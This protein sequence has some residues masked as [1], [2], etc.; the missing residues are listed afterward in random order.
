MNQIEESIFSIQ[1]GLLNRAQ[2]LLEDRISQLEVFERSK[3]FTSN[4]ASEKAACVGVF[5]IRS[6]KFFRDTLSYLISES[7]RTEPK[8]HFFMLPN[9]RALTNVHANFLHLLESGNEDKQALICIAYQLLTMKDLQNDVEYAKVLDMNKNFLATQSVVFPASPA[10]FSYKW[11]QKQKL[12]LGRMDQLLESDVVKKYSSN[13]VA[14]FM[15]KEQYRI[16]STLS[17]FLHGNPYYYDDNPHNERFWI[18]AFSISIT[19]FLIEIIDTYFLNKIN[20][21]DFRVWLLDV[22]RQRGD[23]SNLW[24]SKAHTGKI[25]T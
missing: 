13:V 23:F 22:K 11:M 9:I 19:A 5:K 17:E 15:P 18:V 25:S 24:K 3:E 21:R 16:Y 7:A 14:V 2:N 1:I 10:D 12:T 4:D 6:A 8:V 20:P